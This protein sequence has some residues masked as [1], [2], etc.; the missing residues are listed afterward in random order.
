MVKFLKPG[1]A[2]IV[3]HGR[4]AGRKGI[5]VRSFNDGTRDRPYNHCLVAGISKHPKKGDSE[6]LNEEDGEEVSRQCVFEAGELQP[7]H[8]D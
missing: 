7:Y 1:K 3:L 4:Y 8:A 2:V 5:I 6:G